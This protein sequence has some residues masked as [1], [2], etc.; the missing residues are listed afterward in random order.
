[1]GGDHELGELNA[2]HDFGTD[3]DTSAGDH[4]PVESTGEHVTPSIGLLTF[5]TCVAAVT[6]FGLTGM[7]GSTGGLSTVETLVIAIG[8]GAIAL[9]SVAW[10]MS[11]LYRLRAEGTAYIERS[12]GSAGTVYLPIPAGG[13]GAGK[14][15]LNFQNRTMEYQAISSA[16]ELPTGTVVVVTG[17]AGPDTVEVA[18]APVLEPGDA[19][20]A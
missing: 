4:I 10:A 17:V 7:A 12:I 16:G 1:M 13:H 15:L 8:S 19:L 9:Y 3:G 5:R 11:R 6:F 2:D 18:P 20:S 14:V